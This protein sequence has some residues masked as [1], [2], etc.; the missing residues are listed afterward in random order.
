MDIGGTVCGLLY[1]NPRSLRAVLV[2]VPGTVNPWYSTVKV[3]GTND[4][5]FISP[6]DPVQVLLF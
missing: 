2:T 5:P 4:L 6:T 1:V 3:P